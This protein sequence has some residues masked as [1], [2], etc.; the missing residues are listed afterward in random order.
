MDAVRYKTLRLAVLIILTLGYII[1]S[2]TDCI[3][4]SFGGNREMPFRDLELSDGENE[5]FYS[6]IINVKIYGAVGDGTT[7]DTAAINSAISAASNKSLLIP[8]GTYRIASSITVPS[9]VKIWF[10][11]DAKISVDSGKTLTVNGQLVAERYQIFT[12]DGTVNIIQGACDEVYPEWWG[13][14][15]NGTTDDTT[16]LQKC[17]TCASTLG[18]VKVVK[19]GEKTYKI[20]SALTTGGNGINIIGSS[21]NRSWILASGGCDGIRVTPYAT[22]STRE[23]LLFKNFRIY[24]DSVVTG[25]GIYVDGHRDFTI[26]HVWVGGYYEYRK[27]FEYGIYVTSQPGYYVRI[28]NC[29]VFYCKYGIY[30]TGGANNAVIEHNTIRY[31]A[32]LVTVDGWVMGTRIINNSIETDAGDTIDGNPPT[33]RLVTVF[34]RD[35]VIANNYLEHSGNYN[36][37]LKPNCVG[38]VIYGNSK[39]LHVYDHFEVLDNSGNDTNYYNGKL[40]I[41]INK[42][43]G[44]Y[45]TDNVGG[46]IDMTLGSYSDYE[47]SSD[48]HPADLRIRARNGYLALQADRDKRSIELRSHTD[49]GTLTTPFG[50]F[51]KT[52]GNLLQYSW[53]FTGSGATITDK[54]VV[55]PDGTLMGS[56]II[57]GNV[58][59]SQDTTGSP[60]T[61]DDVYNYSVWLRTSEK[62]KVK[63]RLT[64][65]GT[66]YMCEITNE[67][68]RYSIV[69]IKNTEGY[70]NITNSIVPSDHDGKIH[71]LEAFGG[72]FVVM[73]KAVTGTVDSKVSTTTTWMMDYGTD[74]CNAGINRGGYIQVYSPSDTSKVAH[75]YID[76]IESC[77]GFT[78]GDGTEP[79]VGDVVTGVSDAQTVI[80]QLVVESGSFSNGDAVGWMRVKNVR[81]NFTSSDTL[82]FPNATATCDYFSR[83]CVLTF[84]RAIRNIWNSKTNCCNGDTYQICPKEWTVPP[85]YTPTDGAVIP[86]GSANFYAESIATST[87]STSTLT[88]STLTAST[89]ASNLSIGDNHI[90]ISSNPSADKWSGITTTFT[91]GEN[92]VLGDV[93]YM[94]SN[95]KMYKAD[96]DA[97]LTAG[98][99]AIATTTINT[100]TTGTFLLQGVIHLHTLNPSWTIGSRVYLSTTAGAMTQTQPNGA[101]DVIQVLGTAIANDILLFNPNLVMVEHN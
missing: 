78:D 93:C 34:G 100:D 17:I 9:N 15:G 84:T 54:C 20:T 82:T 70:A 16:A 13:A 50:G 45:S 73:G 49:A 4:E 18:N 29:R 64:T 28:L 1:F 39:A 96:A 11:N 31:G 22:G 51:G 58:F 69:G 59:V 19:L 76:D 66:G 25:Y 21:M 12:G 98:V 41:R 44:Q 68:R 99:I 79:S 14:V 62:D 27:G 42:E 89:L 101:D 63:S 65:G 47:H 81:G 40:I 36:I 88:T 67:W 38:T 46:I 24:S 48:W 55:G 61:K 32:R 5:L 52:Y 77:L 72:Q 85:P 33:E 87:L 53:K 97:I 86:S 3:Q 6:G 83:N 43:E 23:Q 35:T 57:G 71:T 95:G 26:D 30:I 2:I 10:S 56:R 80:T 90:H 92:L 8:P 60:V 37:E 75:G 7:D 74:F 91:A 94:N